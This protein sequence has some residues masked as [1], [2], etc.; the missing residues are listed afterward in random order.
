[1]RTVS[2]FSMQHEVST[3]YCE[4]TL[5]SSL[6]RRQGSAYSGLLLGVSNSASS[7]TNALTYWYGATLITKGEIDFKQLMTA[8]MAL[9][10][11]AIGLGQALLGLGDQKEGL[12]AAKRIFESIDNGINSAIDGLSKSGL[13]PPQRA[14]GR[15]ELKNV[16]FRYPTRPETEVCKDYSLVIEPGTTVALVGPSGSGKS[17]IMNLLLRNY[18]PLE[19]QV[20]MDGVDIKDLNVRWLRAQI[21]YVGQEPVLFSGSISDNIQRGRADAVD[22][23]LKSLQEIIEEHSHARNDLCPCFMDVNGM[24]DDGHP[25]HQGTQNK[26]SAGRKAEPSANKSVISPSND[27]E[28]GLKRDTIPAPTEHI[29][30]DVI[31]AAMAGNA[32]DFIREFTEGYDTDVG[33]SSA[34]VSG[35]QKQRIAIARALIKRPAVLLLDEATSALDAASER[36]VQQ[37]IDVLQANKTQTTI[38]IAHRLTT[39]VNADNIVVIDQGMVCE[40]GTHDALLR[41]GGLYAQLWAKQ[42]QGGNTAEK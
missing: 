36:V 2:A 29:P 11:S 18:D 42:Q 8:M 5:A 38:I 9:M 15:I 24:S 40:Q 17:T 1:M 26:P 28:S 21:G 41:K 12:L 20:M 34:M 39:I 25:L 7:F 19:G 32:H 10:L 27:V 13:R 6:K 30:S 22:I 31:E 33:E 3:Q 16:S 23:P 14:T 4:M 37:S 35:G